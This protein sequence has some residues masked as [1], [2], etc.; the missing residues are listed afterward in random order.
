GI[1]GAGFALLTGSPLLGM[2]FWTLQW[3]LPLSFLVE[4]VMALALGG[5]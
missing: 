2:I 4:G 1:V 5:R 3:P